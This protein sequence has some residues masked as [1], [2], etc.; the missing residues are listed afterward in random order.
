MEIIRGGER[1]RLTFEYHANRP[2]YVKPVITA[3]VKR[4]GHTWFVS[5]EGKLYRKDLFE[6]QYGR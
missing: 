6:K 3:Q 1:T 2:L 5:R 4:D